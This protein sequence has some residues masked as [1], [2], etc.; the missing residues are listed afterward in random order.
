M[1]DASVVLHASFIVRQ[2]T[3]KQLFAKF[4]LTQWEDLSAEFVVQHSAAKD[5]F[6][7]LV[8]QHSATSELYAKFEAQ[9][10]R[11]LYADFTVRHSDTADLSSEFIVRHTDTQNLF[12]K[13]LV[14]RP[15]SADLPA[16]F[17]VGQDSRDI[18]CYFV[19]GRVADLK[20]VFIVRQETWS[21]NPIKGFFV[22]N[23]YW[24]DIHAY[25]KITRPGT[26]LTLPA[27]LI[28][29]HSSSEDIQ[30]EFIVKHDAEVNL[31]GVLIVQHT[32][33]LQAT[34]IITRPGTENLYA[35]F[36]T[37]QFFTNL[38]AQFEV[39]HPPVDYIPSNY[40]IVANDL[41]LW[42]NTRL[43]QSRGFIG[44]PTISRLNSGN[45]PGTKNTAVISSDKEPGAYKEITVGWRPQEAIEGVSKG[46]VDE[47]GVESEQA[48]IDGAETKVQ[49]WF[50]VRPRARVDALEPVSSRD[51]WVFEVSEQVSYAE[52]ESV[53]TSDGYSYAVADQTVTTLSDSTRLTNGY[54]TEHDIENIPPPEQQI[55]PDYLYM[56]QDYFDSDAIGSSDAYS[57]DVI[58]EVLPDPVQEYPFTTDPWVFDVREITNPVYDSGAVRSGDFTDEIIYD[59]IQLSY[60]DI[61]KIVEL[62][63]LIDIGLS[64]HAE[65]TLRQET[66]D[67]IA[68]FTTNEITNAMHAQFFVSP[69]KNLFA[70]FM[71]VLHD[72]VTLF[73]EMVTRQSA[74]VNLPTVM[75]IDHTYQMPCEMVIRHTETKDLFSEF[76]VTHWVD[77]PGEFLLRQETEDLAAEFVVRQKA[78]AELHAEFIVAIPGSNELFAQFYVTNKLTGWDYRVELETDYTKID[79]TLANFPVAIRL[80]DSAGIASRDLSGIFDELGG[81]WQRIA[82]TTADGVTQLYV[83]VE[84]WDVSGEV[85]VLW[86]AI[87]SALSSSAV[88][89]FLYYDVNHVN[90]T[91]YVDISG[92]GV[93]TNVWD[94]DFKQ[95]NHCQAFG[96]SL[97]DAT[98][99]AEDFDAGSIQGV[100]DGQLG[101]AYDLDRAS[102]DEAIITSPNWNLSGNTLSLE[103]FCKPNTDG[104]AMGGIFDMDL[105][106]AGMSMR[107]I[108][109]AGRSYFTWQSWL[110][111]SY[112]VSSESEVLGNWVYFGFR[113]HVG[114]SIRE[115]VNATAT[116]RV[117]MLSI[118]MAATGNPR[119]IGGEN[120]SHYFDGELGEIRVSKIAR[121]PAYFTATYY[122]L[123]DNLLTYGTPGPV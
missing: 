69:H 7:G 76:V 101:K 83:D 78:S 112:V 25:M 108:T 21:L 51:I 43:P 88:K 107:V 121:D 45:W 28:V 62:E 71:V 94:A 93:A 65:F 48:T 1:V 4:E 13:L 9:V 24:T 27:E 96:T 109:R 81:D 15:G 79:T 105:G 117:G 41:D 120:G 30:A 47:S 35:K 80:S 22:Y 10:T 14:T 63:T 12:T 72:E 87:P 118:N 56:L 53:S 6:T 90:N 58:E 37:G 66:E 64:I 110:N 68:F 52:P 50:I 38:F 75:S 115:Y 34:A 36:I 55:P 77:I 61:V 5:L 73:G 92:Q 122:T 91:S 26:P 33:D 17:E 89:L 123:D 29:R 42:L 60:G 39:N 95:V 113:W 114:A 59:Y 86:A 103:I 18:H 82:V 57:I 102:H 23:H 32:L 106:V 54:F 74:G 20:A 3:S 31:K 98:S 2:E 84:M 46:A 40:I 85:A 67:L 19:V 44:P 16:E 100:V 99:N 11:N 111:A 70:K 8:V 49:S 104:T 97:D 116:T 119:S